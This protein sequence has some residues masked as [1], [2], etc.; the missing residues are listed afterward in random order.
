MLIL[1]FKFNL[2]LKK[3]GYFK[4]FLF[5]KVDFN[6]YTI[7]WPLGNSGDDAVHKIPHKMKTHWQNQL[8]QFSTSF[9]RIRYKKMSNAP[10]SKFFTCPCH[11]ICRAEAVGLSLSITFSK[12]RFLYAKFEAIL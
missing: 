4:Q 3:F 6:K 1:T 9:Y 12:L 10:S 8:N 2:F 11:K 5:F 7:Q